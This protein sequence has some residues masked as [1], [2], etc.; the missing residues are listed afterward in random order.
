MN[1]KHINVASLLV[2]LML[3]VTACSSLPAVSAITANNNG[4]AAQAPTNPQSD[5]TTGS[6]NSQSAPAVAPSSLAGYET[7]L[8]DIY[9]RVNPSV[10]NIQVTEKASNSSSN[11]QNSGIPGF[12][13]FFGSPNDQNQPQ[14]P[15]VSQALG[16][17]FVWDTQGHIVTN[18]HVV[19][20]ADSIQVKFSDGTIVSAKLVGTDVNSDLAVIQLENYS[21]KL[22]PIQVIDSSSVKV[23]QVAVAIGNPFGLENTMTAGIVS[24]V[25]RS[26]PT[27]MTATGA[28]FTIP[29]II[30]TDAPINPGNSGGVLV[31]DTGDLIGVTS[32]IE[33]QSGSSAG[34]GFAIPSSIV[35]KVIPALISTGKYEHSFL[36]LTGTTLTPD[37]AKAMGIDTATRGVLVVEVSAGDPA[38]KAGINGSSKS[39]TINGHTKVGG[40]VITKIDG[41]PLNSMDDLISY[42]SGKTEVGQKVT[43]TTVRNGSEKTIEVTLGARPNTLSANNTTTQP[44]PGSA[45]GSVYLGVAVQPVTSDIAAAMGL[46][47][48]QKGVLVEEVETGSPADLAGLKGSF[49]PTIINSKRIMIGG[50]IIVAAGGQPI[51]T[52]SDL[53]TAISSMQSGEQ[54]TLSILRDGK[55]QE[56]IVT[57]ANRP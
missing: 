4:L 47:S 40:D 57:L 3:T 54:V 17:G 26:L 10:V 24:A 38:D 6:S 25:G 42:L 5:S 46:S 56:V 49:K 36:G 41:Q 52:L 32:A 1:T 12:Q 9:S 55:P 14:A 15:R 8:E 53:K 13:F 31:N 19:A 50:D 18:N 23:G 21:G 7:T 11:S 22:T 29:D 39:V 2:I 37:L 16:S 27:D 51:N 28:G 20:N 33:S 43:L 34:I 48:D 44:V 45:A 30:Q 35:Q